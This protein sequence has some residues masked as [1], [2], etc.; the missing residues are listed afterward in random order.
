M[1]KRRD[2]NWSRVSAELEKIFKM[3]NAEEIEAPHET[4]QAEDSRRIDRISLPSRDTD[5]K[6]GM[7]VDVLV[8]T[9]G[10][11]NQFLRFCHQLDEIIHEGADSY[12]GILRTSTLWDGITCI[13]IMLEPGRLGELMICLAVLPEVEKVEDGMFYGL[14][15]LSGNGPYSIP[16][17]PLNTRSPDKIRVVMKKEIV[18]GY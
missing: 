4:G 3:K 15:S 10:N 7:T 8:E 14:K 1:M 5:S 9:H 11:S 13:T 2:M 17:Y 6:F 18:R 12:G 16:H